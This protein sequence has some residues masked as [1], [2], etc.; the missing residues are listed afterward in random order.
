[1]PWRN[2]DELLG[3]YECYESK[4]KAVKGQISCN[5]KNHEPFKDIN[6]EDLPRPY[7]NDSSDEEENQDNEFSIYD[8]SLIGLDDDSDNQGRVS[9]GAAASI[10][11]I[12]MSNETFYEMCSQ[13]NKKQLYL[14]NFIMQYA[15]KCRYAERNNN[16]APSSFNMFLSGGGGV[17]KSFLIKLITEYLRRILRYPEQLLDKQPSVCVTASAGKAAT[18]SNGTTVHL[19]FQLPIRRVGRSFEYTKA[20]SE[21]IHTLRNKYKHLKVLIIDEISMLG[22]ETFNHLN[23]RLQD[24][25]GNKFSF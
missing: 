7:E 2:E 18:N 3:D 24:I 16:V 12:S 22:N 13:M 9:S 17:G 1:M 20:G 11:V 5:I 23:L 6:F 10:E 4:Y 19:A 14:L 15:V 25:M 21:R 8:P